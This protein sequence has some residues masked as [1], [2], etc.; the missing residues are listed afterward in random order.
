[1]VFGWVRCWCIL[2]LIRS[3]VITRLLW[4]RFCLLGFLFGAGVTCIA[5]GLMLLLGLFS[6]FFICMV[7]DLVFYL[8][9]FGW[10]FDELWVILGVIIYLLSW[11]FLASALC[12]W[13]FRL[14][15]WVAWFGVCLGTLYCYFCFRCLCMLL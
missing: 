2:D 9:M 11:Y 12:L 14:V 6:E 10:L 8:L 13:L 3:V 15:W 4:F 7:I 1:M 5:C